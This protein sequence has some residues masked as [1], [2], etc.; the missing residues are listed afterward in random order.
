MKTFS[1]L[2]PPVYSAAVRASTTCLVTGG[3]GFIGRYVVRALHQ[4]G[5]RVRLL[6][7]RPAPAQ[8]L[9]GDTVEIVTGDLRDPAR[10]T[11][12][13][14]DVASVIHLGAVYQFGRGARHEMLATNIAGTQHLLQAA[15]NARVERFVHI[16]SSG[17]LVN[18][19]T[20]VTETDFPTHVSLRQPYRHSKWRGELAA[21]EFAKRGLPVVI[22]SPTSP[23]GAEDEAPTPTGQIVSDFLAGRFPFVARTMLNFVDVAELAAGILAVADRGRC[24][25]RYILANHNIWLGDFLRLLARQTGQSAPRF[26]IPLGGILAGGV[27]GE[28]AGSSRLCWETAWH[29]L[30]TQPFAVQKATTELDWHARVPL[31]TSARAAIAWYRHRI[32]PSSLAPEPPLAATHAATS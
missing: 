31:A 28:L 23:L 19:R 29:C 9:F 6:T 12:A 4:R 3:T 24:G 16:S 22:A 5:V 26:S 17:V 15:W 30:R 10:V 2:T 13:C 7:R 18:H 14:R 11:A 27:I 32:V 21:L 20:P 25:E 8:T 1:K